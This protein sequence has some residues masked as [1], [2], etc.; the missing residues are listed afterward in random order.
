M[1][2]AEQVAKE[3]IEK[4]RLGIMASPGIITVKDEWR[5]KVL[6]DALT[7]AREQGRQMERER[8]EL[9]A[10]RLCQCTP[11]GLARLVGGCL[12]CTVADALRPTEPE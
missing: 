3:L 9:I 12:A 11:E 2:D 5:V 4:L 7:T 10:R 8:C 1:T 6:V